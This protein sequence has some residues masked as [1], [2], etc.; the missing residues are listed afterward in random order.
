M[1]GMPPAPPSCNLWRPPAYSRESFLRS[2]D[3]AVNRSLNPQYTDV[4]QCVNLALTHTGS[5]TLVENLKRL[6]K[7][8]QHIHR[9][10][11]SHFY[12]IGRRCII[13]TLRDPVLRLLS[14]FSFEQRANKPG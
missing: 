4:A 13:M 2:I 9:F 1:V 11:L 10:N 6:S 12:R 5:T 8:A 3:E 7:H 14:A